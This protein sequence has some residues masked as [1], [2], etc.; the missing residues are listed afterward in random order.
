MASYT[1]YATVAGLVLCAALGILIARIKDNDAR[2]QALFGL[3]FF[4]LFTLPGAMFHHADG[5]AA[6][7]YLEHRAYLPTIGLLIACASVLTQY[8]RPTTWNRVATACGVVC[9]VLLGVTF[10][11]VRNYATPIAFYDKAVKANPTSSLA[12]NNRGLIREKNGDLDGA[13]SDYTAALEHDPTYAQAYVN[14]GNR[15]GAAGDEERAK[16]DYRNAVKYKPTMFPAW[17][18][19]GNYYLDMHQLD[20]AY[21]MYSKAAEMNPA[22]AQTHALL[23][24]VSSLRGNNAEAETHLS[25]SLRLNP[26][27]AQN[28]LARGKVRL[29]LQNLS[30]ARTDMQ[31]SASLGNAEAAQLL[32]ELPR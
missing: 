32:Q 17:F 27:N 13:M 19:L 28:W 10:G 30:G 7:D 15:F 14:R 11:H 21:A 23:G 16:S 31:Q 6:Y 8:I 5:A 22:Y 18:N 25:E 26:S 1:L 2:L 3:A 12:L 20:S 29:A 24:V 4:L 9:L